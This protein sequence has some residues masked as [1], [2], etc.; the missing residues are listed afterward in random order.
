MKK[1]EIH[2]ERREVA[3]D[4][5]CKW[6]DVTLGFRLSSVALRQQKDARYVE[7]SFV[8]YIGHSVMS[9]ETARVL[10]SDDDAARVIAEEKLAHSVTFE[11]LRD[12]VKEISTT[13]DALA[14]PLTLKTAQA[15]VRER[16][17]S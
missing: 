16:S 9:V 12:L 13:P 3:E 7:V 1:I 15:L 4:E 11:A 2:E 5:L 8:K 10:A 6:L 17:G 14:N